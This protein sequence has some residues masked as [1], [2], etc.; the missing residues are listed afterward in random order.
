MFP[1]LCLP[2]SA[3]IFIFPVMPFVNGDCLRQ[4]PHKT[5]KCRLI[6]PWCSHTGCTECVANILCDTSPSP[7]HLCCL[8]NSNS[9]CQWRKAFH[10][11]RNYI[12]RNDEADG[13]SRKT[14]TPDIL[15][16]PCFI[17][18]LKRAVAKC[19]RSPRQYEALTKVASLSGAATS[20]D[21]RQSC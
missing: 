21:I 15:T 11:P 18:N 19:A 7:V 13:R 16:F 8:V 14:T 9:K 3:K 2:C 5:I 12:T 6:D 4:C 10:I 20:F 1:V 17:R